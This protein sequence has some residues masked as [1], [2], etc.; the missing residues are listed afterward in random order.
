MQSINIQYNTTTLYFIAID[1]VWNEWSA[2]EEGACSETCGDGQL[3]ATRYRSILLAAENGGVQCVGDSM[4][5]EIRSCN[6]GP[7][8]I[9]E[10]F[11]FVF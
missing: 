3:L 5:E 4:Q 2:F 10:Y 9:G 11:L 1:C 7:C 8:E 6:L